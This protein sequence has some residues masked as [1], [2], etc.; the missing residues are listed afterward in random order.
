MIQTS[1]GVYRGQRHHIRERRRHPTQQRSPSVLHLSLF[2]FS[3]TLSVH[4]HFHVFFYSIDFLPF[5]CTSS[6][7]RFITQ[8]K[9]P[10]YTWYRTL[11][12]SRSLFLC[13]IIT[14][15]KFKYVFHNNFEGI[16]ISAMPILFLL[17]TD[18][19]RII[20]VEFFA[21]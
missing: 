4:F 19:L 9:S 15:N 13:F 21:K 16:V 10:F 6:S 2:S 7:H 1:I 20:N 8:S 11:E 14:V 18:F 12:R 17:E 5:L 3:L